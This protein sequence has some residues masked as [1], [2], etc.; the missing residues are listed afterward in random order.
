MRRRA[1]CWAGEWRGSANTAN[2]NIMIKM[3]CERV[4]REAM[5][6][7]IFVLSI[8]SLLIISFSIIFFSI[9]LFWI[10]CRNGISTKRQ[11]LTSVRLPLCDRVRA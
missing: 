3:G 11:P 1:S 8:M 10:I 6:I 9:I 2:V 7:L 4:I 5:S